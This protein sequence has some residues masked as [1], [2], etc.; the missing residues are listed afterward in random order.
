MPLPFGLERFWEEDED[1]QPLLQVGFL[2]DVTHS[3][4]LRNVC[5]KKLWE[6]VNSK[7][8]WRFKYNSKR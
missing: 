6:F 1:E 4:A 5:H 8:I 7:S 3:E 2:L